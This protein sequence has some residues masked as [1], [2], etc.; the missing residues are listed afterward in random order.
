MLI[1]TR[2][3]TEGNMSSITAIVEGSGP[4]TDTAI[5]AWWQI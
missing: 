3:D 5:V 4:S 2:A 1:G